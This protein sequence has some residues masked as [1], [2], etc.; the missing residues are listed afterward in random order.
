VEEIDDIERRS[1][2]GFIFL[3]NSKS[4]SFEGTQKLHLRRVLRVLD[5]LHK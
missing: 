4:P 3:H 1:L 2:W 5:G